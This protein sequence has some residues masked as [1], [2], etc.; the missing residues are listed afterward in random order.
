V[1]PSLLSAALVAQA[2]CGIYG[3]PGA[4]GGCVVPAPAGGRGTYLQYIN[5]QLWVVP[6]APTPYPYQ[7][8]TPVQPSSPPIY[9]APAYP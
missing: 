7:E 9:Q 2:V 8:A 6:M 5:G 1:T 3:S 4:P